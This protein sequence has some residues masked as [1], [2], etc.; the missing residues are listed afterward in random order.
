MQ[1]I[2]HEEAVAELLDLWISRPRAH[3]AVP[4][5]TFH[6]EP[7]CM[8]YETAINFPVYNGVFIQRFTEESADRRIQELS[9]TLRKKGNDFVW[10]LLPGATPA[11]MDRRVVAAGATHRAELN[12]MAICLNDLAPA[13]S[14]PS[15]VEIVE[16]KDEAAI[17]EYAKIYPLLFNAPVETWIQG[18]IDTEVGLF[19]SG[20]AFYR[21]YL[22]IENGNAIAAA[23]TCVHG[24]WAGLE[25]L[26]TLPEARNRGIGCALASHALLLDGENG[27]TKASLW[28]GPGADGLYKRMGFQYVAKA[29]AYT[30]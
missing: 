24:K 1:A 3:C 13:P 5:G 16:A 29:N 18:V 8:W 25:T 11:D 12:G 21:Y 28:A 10:L 2:D 17:I 27:C 7:D 30:M 4:T 26:L 23:S 9:E 20:Q 6:E 19:R 22:A 14:L 15:G